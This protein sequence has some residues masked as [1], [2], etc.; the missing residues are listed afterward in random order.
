M[1]SVIKNKQTNSQEG[2]VQTTASAQAPHSREHSRRTA[3]AAGK[4]EGRGGRVERGGKVRVHLKRTKR[5][6]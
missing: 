1:I 6:P 3:G 2:R 4:Q 5:G